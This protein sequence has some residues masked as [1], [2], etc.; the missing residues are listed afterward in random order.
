MTDISPVKPLLSVC[1]LKVHFPVKGGILQRTFDVQDE[2]FTSAGLPVDIVTPPS[3]GAVSRAFATRCSSV[4]LLYSKLV[5]DT[6]A[7]AQL[8]S[9]S[10]AP[11]A[12]N[13]RSSRSH[14][15][16]VLTPMAPLVEPPLP[17]TGKA[18][19]EAENGEESAIRRAGPELR[20]ETRR[21]GGAARVVRRPR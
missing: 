1:D 9:I 5:A 7:V 10:P 12:A 16:C 13:D 17:A 4:A 2:Y 3:T 20:G 6:S 21:S 11:T 18:E 14:A 19:G 15:I 8:L